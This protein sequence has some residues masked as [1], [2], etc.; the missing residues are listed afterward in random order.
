MVALS[1]QQSAPSVL[2]PN[3][4]SVNPG[5]T[6]DVTDAAGNPVF[7]QLEITEHAAGNAPD[8]LVT[9]PGCGTPVSICALA[10]AGDL[11]PMVKVPWAKRSLPLV[12]SLVEHDGALYGYEPAVEPYGIFSN[13][14]LVRKLGRGVPETFGQLLALCQAANPSRTLR[15]KGSA[16]PP[17]LG[18]GLTCARAPA[19]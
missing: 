18:A 4:E 7:Y 2:V 12:T 15:A 8:L 6:V 17:A 16:D 19:G 3:V 1:G 10:K 5:I 9:F 13:D 14:D 11:A